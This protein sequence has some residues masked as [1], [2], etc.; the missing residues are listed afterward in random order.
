MD[1]FEGGEPRLYD[2]DE[3]PPWCH[4]YRKMIPAITAA[5]YRAIEPDP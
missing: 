4:L 5:G 3:G 1:E 2:L